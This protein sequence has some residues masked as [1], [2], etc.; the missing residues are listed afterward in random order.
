MEYFLRKINTNNLILAVL[1]IKIY[2]YGLNPLL[3]LMV[4]I[5]NPTSLN[6]IIERM[7]PM[8]LMVM[9]DNRNKI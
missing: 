2:L 8:K 1:Q 9:I 5:V 4:V 3:T 7:E 6:V